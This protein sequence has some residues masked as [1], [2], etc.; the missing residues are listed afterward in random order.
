MKENNNLRLPQMYNIELY[1]SL[2]EFEKVLKYNL[3][4]LNGGDYTRHLCMKLT[5]LSCH[6]CLILRHISWQNMKTV[7]KYNLIFNLVL[8]I[9]HL[10]RKIT[11]LSCH[12]C[13]ILSYILSW[14]NMETVKK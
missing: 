7:L 4:F 1:S 6:R 3:V 12:R 9:R 11:I 8:Y 14:Q 2:A 10:C 13:L 5:I